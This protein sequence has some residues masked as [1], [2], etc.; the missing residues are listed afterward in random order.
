MTASIDFDDFIREELREPEAYEPGIPWDRV[1]RDYGFAPDEVAKLD[2]NENPYGPAPLVRQRLAEAN[3]H[4][5]PDPEQL[6]AREAIASYVGVGVE[7]VIGGNGA[8]ELI[9]LVMRLFRSP[10]ELIVPT[11]T[12]AMYGFYGRLSGL[13]I[14]EAPRRESDWSLDVELIELLVTP[15]TKLI[16]VCSPNNPTGDVVS[17]A[18]LE[19]LLSLGPLVL[20]DEAYA[21]FAHSNHTACALEY[22]NLLVTRT[23]S[24]WG[25]LAGLRAGYLVG[26]P[27]IIKKL[28]VTKSPVN[29]SLP[30][31]LGA[32]ACVEQK[33]FLDAN[34]A[35]IR[36]E[37]ERLTG[38]LSRLPGVQVWPSQANFVLCRFAG[39]DGRRLRDDL[40]LRGVFTR[41]FDAPRLRG[42]LRITVARPEDSDRLLAALATVGE[43]AGK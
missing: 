15:Q 27:Q 39:R 7:N 4:L 22:P 17:R 12:F 6:E 28:L 1:L 8:D 42:C 43:P 34:A 25:G 37:R 2:S 18:E 20:L 13:A 14:V 38:L 16:C 10:G 21:E 9:D 29:M 36:N 24:K 5:Y 33:Q 26:S 40:R 11:P 19:R 35:K 23:F 30:A 3:L 32:V 41:H 31:Q